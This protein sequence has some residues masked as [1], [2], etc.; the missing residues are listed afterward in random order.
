[1]AELRR[2]LAGEAVEPLADQLAAALA[3]GEALPVGAGLIPTA[4]D[5]D[6]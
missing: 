4:L 6:R 5:A 2:I 1:M 3:E